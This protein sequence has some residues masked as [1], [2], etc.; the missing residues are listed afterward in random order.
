MAEDRGCQRGHKGVTWWCAC[1]C[2]CGTYHSLTARG[3]QP[4]CITSV[5]SY[6]FAFVIVASVP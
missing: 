1:V 4:T 6:A 2:A 5:A 3:Q